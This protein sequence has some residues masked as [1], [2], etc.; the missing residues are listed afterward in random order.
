MREDNWEIDG[1]FA[2]KQGKVGRIER[3]DDETLIATFLPEGR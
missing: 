1:I 3:D 2:A